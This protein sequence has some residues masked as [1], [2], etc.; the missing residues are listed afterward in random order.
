MA[1]SVSKATKGNCHCYRI[2]HR[3]AVEHF[4]PA[5]WFQRSNGRR[6]PPELER[7][8]DCRP[9]REL[10][11]LNAHCST[12]PRARMPTRRTTRRNQ[13][14]SRRCRRRSTTPLTLSSRTWKMTRSPHRTPARTRLALAPA[15]AQWRGRDFHEITACNCETW[16]RT[17][18]RNLAGYGGAT[19]RS[20]PWGIFVPRSALW[21]HRVTGGNARAL[22]S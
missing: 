14:C 20:A 18:D 12:P 19:Q 21:C 13:N 10:P 16:L 9:R 8:L 2:R 1:G 17:A 15:L 6:K 3:L 4:R 5:D 22:R 11:S 7:S